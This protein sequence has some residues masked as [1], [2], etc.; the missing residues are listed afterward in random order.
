M[1]MS[2]HQRN[3]VRV[4]TFKRVYKPPNNFLAAVGNTPSPGPSK[5][6]SYGG[7]RHC[8]HQRPGNAW[9]SQR[10]L[11]RGEEPCMRFAEASHRRPPYGAHSRR[12]YA[13][14]LKFIL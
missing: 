14:I 12:L 9:M 5:A 3:M 7:R 11:E 1:A 6:R 8:V 4:D 13:H 10:L 2:E